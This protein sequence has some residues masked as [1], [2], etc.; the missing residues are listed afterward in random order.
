MAVVAAIAVGAYFIIG[1]GNGGSADVADDGPHKLTTPA[2]L[3]TEYKKG[4][5][6]EDGMTKSDLQDAESW[7]VKNPKDVSASY[8]AG[9]DADNPLAGKLLTFGGVYGDIE[10]PE[11]AVDGFFGFMKKDAK[12]EDVT[13]VG[14]PKAYEPSSLDGA[15]L[16]CQEAKFD[17][18]D[19][20]RGCAE[21][22]ERDVLR[23]GRPQHARLRD[24]DGVLRRGG[25]QELGPHGG[26]RHHRQ[27]PQG[28]PR[29]ALSGAYD[30]EG[31]RSSTGALRRNSRACVPLTRSS[32]RPGP[33]RARR[34]G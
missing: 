13:F 7:G 20:R 6:S 23:L 22:D 2:T 8:Q 15:V 29:Q 19:S 26:G 33:G 17:N 10:D 11:K 21:V 30:G 12:D 3:L 9:E 32:A 27:G 1:G 25:R 28:G 34:A 31:P 18:S 16:K 4:K 24:A 5:D 14:S